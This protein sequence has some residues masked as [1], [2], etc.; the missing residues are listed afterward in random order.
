[1]KKTT[2]LICLFLL[3]HIST[4]CCAKSLELSPH[5]LKKN[6]NWTD[7][8]T[9][10]AI[11]ALASSLLKEHNNDIQ[12]KQRLAILSLLGEHQKVLDL[13]PLL[14]QKRPFEYIHYELFSSA[15]IAQKGQH[16]SF[17]SAFN[18]SFEKSTQQLSDK[19]IYHFGRHQGYSLAQG[20]PYLQAL[21]KNLQHNTESSQ[22]NILKF[23]GEFQRFKIYSKIENPLNDALKRTLVQRYIINENVLIK[24]PDGATLSATVVRKKGLNSPQPTALQSNIYTDVRRNLWTAINAVNHGYV[25]VVS[26]T[27]GKRLSADK[28]EPYKYDGKDTHTVID[29]ISKQ[30]WSDGQIGMYGGSYSGFVQWATAEYQHPALKTIVPY[31]AAIP[32]QGLPMENNVFL[33][34]NYAWPFYVTNNKYLDID[35]YYDNDRWQQLN[36][37]WYQSGR[38]YR[39]IDQVDGLPN[40][41]LQEWLQHPAYDDYW[42]AMVPYQAAFKNIDI[43]VLSVTGY[44]DDGQI[45]ALHYLKEHEKYHTNP[46]HYLIIGPYD[47][48]GAQGKPA[49]DLRGYS[50]DPVA[51]INIEAITFAWFDYVLKGTKKPA[52]L[53]NRINYQVMGTNQ[54]FHAPSLQQLNQKK[55]RFYLS[56]DQTNQHFRL[57]T[58]Q[59]KT[60]KAVQQ[61]VDL[62]D[63]SESHNRYYPWP[64][65]GEVLDV[66]NGYAF[67]TDPLDR[68]IEFSGSISGEMVVKTNKKD[69][70]LG[71]VVYEILPTDETFHLAYYLGRA[72]YAKNMS[73][74]Y[75]LQPDVQQTIPFERS[76]IVGKLIKKGSRI[77]VLVNVNINSGA[78]INYGTGKDV[79]DENISDGKEP[80]IIDWM[81]SSYIDLPIKPILKQ[82]TEKHIDS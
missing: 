73:K 77:A 38:S 62:Q 81:N 69:F 14:N 39:A 65:V 11:Q 26:D 46:N 57:K 29:W 15:K 52:L 23:I 37:K 70:D 51:Q 33:T 43:P 63:R 4:Y 25:G 54:W 31:V 78:Q 66:P 35:L 34:A 28:I 72:S 12:A 68:D 18:T 47:H 5:L 58:I 82:K 20:I 44:Y 75:L 40:P 55:Q 79:S 53:K 48:F 76:R 6:I 59:E 22:K 56:T 42:Q 36:E 45:S 49:K 67:I 8:E 19:D 50:I 16:I 24:T 9:D 74:R 2:F 27:R 61:K 1:M 21:L 13:I 32:G 60:L 41:W 64:I 80:L 17:A 30:T 71:L 3:S 10:Q 7:K